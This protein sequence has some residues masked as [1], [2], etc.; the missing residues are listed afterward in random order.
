MARSITS[1]IV[2]MFVKS[3]PLFLG[4][5][6]AIIATSAALGWM[7]ARLKVLPGTTAVWGVAPGG[8]SVM[9]LMSG[10]FG[11]DPRLVAFMQ[12][13]RVVVVARSRHRWWDGCGP[14]RPIRGARDRVVS[15][16]SLDKLRRD[17]GGGGRERHDRGRPAH[18]RRGR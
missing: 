8:A 12:Y 1:D 13:L 15:C 6:A 14:E 3:W 4:V 5:V 9:M 10:E 17:A 18:S 11:A 16:C 7:M 2:L